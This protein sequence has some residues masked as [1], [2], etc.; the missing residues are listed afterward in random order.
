MKKSLSFCVSAV[1]VGMSLLMLLPF[2]YMLVCSLQETYSPFLI[3]LDVSTYTPDNWLKIFRVSGFTRWL[4]NSVF[5]SL[6]GVL[7]TLTVCSLGAYGF[8]RKS[9][10]GS[11]GLLTFLMVSMVIPFPATVVSLWLIMGKMQLIDSFWPLILPIPSMLGLLLIRGAILS[12]PK[13]MFESARIDGSGDFQI[14]LRVVLPVIRPVLI[15]VAI[16][17][18][19]RSWNSFLWPLIISNSDFTKT[20]PVGLAAMQGRASSVNYG[21]TM[22]G[23]LFNF[24]PPFLL[25]V[26]MQKHF[27]AGITDG[28]IKN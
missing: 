1:F 13:E 27:M 28:G 24:L 2:A 18:F 6:A 8:A 25:Y 10:P 19:A 17:Y 26:F 15:T 11:N 7:L 20:L 4:F 12:M 21:I 9:F 22:A 5:I 3:S 16:L 14:Y 23:S